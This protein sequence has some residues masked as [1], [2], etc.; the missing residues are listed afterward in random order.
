MANYTIYINTAPTRDCEALELALAMAAFDHHVN[1]V[2]A[3]AGRHWLNASQAPRCEGGKSPSK[4]LA[5]L[6]MYGIKRVAAVGQPDDNQNV[7]AV[8]WI[9]PQHAQQQLQSA[10]VAM[11]LS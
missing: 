6:P 5:S 2:F 9:S 8:D 1:L 7:I 4:L 10:D 11:V 3:G